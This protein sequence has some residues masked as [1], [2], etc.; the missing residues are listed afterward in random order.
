MRTGGEKDV[1]CD[2]SGA[3]LQNDFFVLKN[4]FSKIIMAVAD[5]SKDNVFERGISDGNGLYAIG[6][7]YH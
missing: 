1:I 7:G 2:H 3:K 4:K 5:Q 6:T